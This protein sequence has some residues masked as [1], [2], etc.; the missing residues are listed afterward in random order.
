MLELTLRSSVILAAAW[1]FARA[2]PRAT[3]ATRHLVWHGAI[4]AVLAAPIISPLVPRFGVPLIKLQEV[5]TLE[6]VEQVQEVQQVAGFGPTATLETTC[7]RC[8]VCTAC[9]S[10]AACTWNAAGAV[11]TLGTVICGVWFAAAWLV[12]WNNVRRATPA[13]LQWQ[14]EVNAL[15]EKLRMAR[16]VRV[17]L[18]PAASSPVAAG[19]LRA[20][21]LLPQLAA[22]W[23]PE[24][25]RTV[26]HH[27]LAHIRRHD[28]RAQ[29][30]THVAC[31]L[32]WFNPLVWVAASHLR[33][34]RERACD[35][36]VLRS[37][38]QPSSY[39]A[40]LLDI[41]R[42]LRP[43]LRPSAALAMARRSEIEGRL[44]AVLA[45]KRRTPFGATRWAIVTVLG[46]ATV[47]ALGASSA[48][49][50]SDASPSSTPRA[51]MSVSQDVAISS[52][53]A[54]ANR[55]RSAAKATLAASSNPEERQR[56]VMDLASTPQA[57]A[58]A[59][60]Q[61]ALDD[62]DQDVREKA[63]LALSFMSGSDVVPA[64]LQALA[65]RDA[66]VREKAAIGLALR[67][68]ARVIE[69]LIGAMQDRDAQVREKVAIALGTSGDPR[70]RVPLV[71]A[72]RDPDSQVREKAAAAL[73]MLGARQ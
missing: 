43:S 5:Q 22:A 17:R 39:A 15:C 67:R 24:R 65:D 9:T 16:D 18:V 50:R 1:L 23:S 6:G 45:D 33:L 63:A 34:E 25:R 7:T 68:D 41:A 37:G 13:P 28:C 55:T 52:A 56:A 57:D 49:G 20:T 11:W 3:A 32:Y 58:I 44:L 47:A 73:I 38:A 70:A 19:V 61:R 62:P 30:L 59:P 60:L 26:L 35:D 40:H 69:P 46:I 64:L 42:E 21:I 31:A 4:I 71:D 10:C 51:T 29:L 72:L 48:P 54:E 66:Q 8:T 14:L 53:R 2:L 12:T 27:E 36:E